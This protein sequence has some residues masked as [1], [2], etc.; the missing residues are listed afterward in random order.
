MRMAVIPNTNPHIQ[1]NSSK[2]PRK[3]DELNLKCSL[4]SKEK[5]KTKAMLEI[6]NNFGGFKL[7]F[8]NS[9]KPK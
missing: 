3:L 8:K 4:K 6:K 7:H 9:V 5:R 1:Y 2:C